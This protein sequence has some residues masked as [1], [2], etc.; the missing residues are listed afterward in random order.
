M[1]EDNFLA[2]ILNANYNKLNAKYRRLHS[3]TDEEVSDKYTYRRIYYSAD[4]NSISKR[5]PSLTYN[6]ND[7]LKTQMIFS[8]TRESAPWNHVRRRR[9]AMSELRGARSDDR[10][11]TLPRRLCGKILLPKSG[12]LRLA[13]ARSAF[14]IRRKID[15]RRKPLQ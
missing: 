11:S 10:P 6:L 15:V 8:D 14:C 7:R 5:R 1:Q 12:V 4:D 13:V 2:C 3:Q 9:A